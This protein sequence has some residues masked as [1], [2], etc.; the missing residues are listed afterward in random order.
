MR[1]VINKNRIIGNIHEFYDYAVNNNLDD[2]DGKHK[3]TMYATMVST[4]NQLKLSFK[5]DSPMECKAFET[6][7]KPICVRF[8]PKLFGYDKPYIKASRELKDELK[9]LKIGQEDFSDVI[10][11]LILEHEELI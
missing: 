3:D 9:K 2:Y 11:R 4:K 5:Y 8:Q 6:K 10:W 1:A 7:I